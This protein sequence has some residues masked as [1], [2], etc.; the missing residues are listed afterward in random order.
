[1]LLLEKGII[2]R[3]EYESA[4][5]DLGETVGARAGESFS[6]VLSKWSATLYGFAEGD[7]IFDST[8][9]LNEVPGNSQ[10]AKP[11]SYAANHNRFM[12]SIRNSR[13]GIR[14][15]AP[16]WHHIRAS[17]MVEMDFLGTQATT[18][19]EAATFTSPLFRAR[20]YNLKVETPVIDLLVGQWWSLF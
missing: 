19:S 10:I 3:A 9:S 2:T 1:N 18:T 17:A 15:R 5:R 13:F 11:G 7:F 4:L 6:L 20:H 8:Q 16:E 14:I 12:A